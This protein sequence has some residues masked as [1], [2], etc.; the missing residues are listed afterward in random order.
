MTRKINEL[1]PIIHYK[2]HGV[3]VAVY[4][5]LKGQ[6]REHC[7]CYSCAYFE[8]GENNCPK[9]NLLF[10]FNI[11]AG[12]TTPVWECQTFQSLVPM[13]ENDKKNKN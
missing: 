4:E 3:N 9:A 8:P 7:L 12:M 10:A 2:H 6:H 13:V 11:I 5:N 1:G